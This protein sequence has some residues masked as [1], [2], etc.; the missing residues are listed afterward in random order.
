MVKQLPAR[1][2]I[3]VEETLRG[4]EYRWRDEDKLLENIKK[5]VPVFIMT[6]ASL[7]SIFLIWS[8]FRSCPEKFAPNPSIFWVALVFLAFVFCGS[9]LLAYINLKP[10][11]PFILILS[12]GRIQ[13][14]SGMLSRHS[15]N[16][17]MAKIKSLSDAFRRL[18]E[19][20]A[21]KEIRTAEITH[22]TLETSRI[23]QKLTIDIGAERIE[24]GPT[25]ADAE[26]EWLYE[27]L[28]N[29]IEK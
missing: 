20:C 27:I 16:T 14:E 22:L 28:R 25:L 26:R 15:T 4:T 12:P 6:A 21:P 8:N 13:Y 9:L 2:S 11:K 7:I 3:K 19:L 1:F 18:K 29:H 24:I 10:K 23:R 17:E 5:V